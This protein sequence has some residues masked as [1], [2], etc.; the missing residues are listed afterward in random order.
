MS[1]VVKNSF[2]IRSDTTPGRVEL[3]DFLR[4]GAMILVLLHHSGFPL[5]Q[6]ILAFHMPLFFVL[7]GY[8]EHIGG[9]TKRS[10]KEYFKRRFTRLVV[11][12][13]TFE[14]LN[15]I[16]WCT[17]CVFEHQSLPEIPET[18]I[19]IITCVN[20]NYMGL[21]G[22]LWFL[23]CMFV[24]DMYVWTILKFWRNDRF[25]HIL[26][27]MILFALSIITA[28]VIPFRLP[29]TIDTA[30]FAAAFIMLGYVFG[31][32][33]Q[34]LLTKGNDKCKIIL[35]IGS[36]L[37]LVYAVRYTDVTVLM[38][39]NNYGEYTV[40]I[41][42]AIAGSAAFLIL[43]SYLYRAVK[44][45][46]FLNNFVIWYGNNSLATF[47]IHLTIK[48]FILWYIPVFS[49]WY[50]LFLGMLFLNIPIVNVI[51]CYFPFML[52]KKCNKCTDRL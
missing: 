21:Y 30:L 51:T 19:S 39:I 15:L 14:T 31:D 52:G 42:A 12:Y 6:Y 5:G 36:L 27:V 11:P 20:N 45:A 24:A 28:K 22:R 2:S 34:I 49:I 35:A 13:F 38:F 33:V 4:G 40:S 3:I 8:L 47:P 7:T 17:K 26:S 44:S 23:P 10:L 48:M 9:G 18:V 29:F 46:L 16:I 41:C 43:G 32:A 50:L 1:Q 37:Y 25:S